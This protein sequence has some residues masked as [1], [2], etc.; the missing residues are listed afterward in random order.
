MTMERPAQLEQLESGRLGDSPRRSSTL[1]QSSGIV[2]NY[3]TIN[4]LHDEKHNQRLNRVLDVRIVPL[5]CWLYLLN[6]LDRGNIGNAKVLNQET[7]DDM[8]SQ[9]GMNANG[10]A[11]AV[12]LFSVAYTIFE[13]PSNWVMKHYVRP[14][15][16]LAFLLGSWVSRSSP[17]HHRSSGVIVADGLDQGALTI[18]FAGVK[19]YTTVLVLRLLIGAV[20][21]IV[22][23]IKRPLRMIAGSRVLPRYVARGWLHVVWNWT[24]LMAPWF[25]ALY[26]S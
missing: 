23:M 17:S 14:S 2:V 18:G 19:N 7:K 25:Q 6:F 3:D 5:C 16:W 21:A 13:V 11:V 26:T 12:T 20:S 1:A 9:T 4:D 15:L 8:L 24:P 22:V 10:Y